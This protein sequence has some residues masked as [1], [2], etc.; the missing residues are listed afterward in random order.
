MIAPHVEG[1][2]LLR[3]RFESLLEGVIAS[4]VFADS[5]SAKEWIKVQLQLPDASGPN[6]GN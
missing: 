1:A 5:Q 3:S 4:R 6:P 2:S